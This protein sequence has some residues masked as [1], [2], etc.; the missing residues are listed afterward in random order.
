MSMPNLKTV[1]ISLSCVQASVIELL[2]LTKQ[3]PQRGCPKLLYLN[4]RS[5]EFVTLEL[6]K[7]ILLCLPKLPYLDHALLVEM[8]AKLTERE[9]ETNVDD[10][11]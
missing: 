4:M 3:N 11:V 8:L 1:D 7:K 9:R 10:V 5:S 2:L 6:L